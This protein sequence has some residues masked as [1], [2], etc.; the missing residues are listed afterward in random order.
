MVL[1]WMVNNICKKTLMFI[2]RLLLNK[3]RPMNI[4]LAAS[5]SARPL[6]LRGIGGNGS[7]RGIS[8]PRRGGGPRRSGRGAGRGGLRQPKVV[9]SA[10]DLDAEL[11]AHNA[12]M[13]TD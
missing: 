4:Q 9:K 12:K 7:N 1:V 6:A 11:D 5:L 3:G 13:Q 8:G 2:L 10:A